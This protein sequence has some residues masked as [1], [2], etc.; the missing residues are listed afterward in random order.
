M[1]GEKGISL[2]SLPSL[3][4][5][6][7]LPLRILLP[8]RGCSVHADGP[9]DAV[10]IRKG[11]TLAWPAPSLSGPSCVPVTLWTLSSQPANGMDEYVCHYKICWLLTHCTFILLQFFDSQYIQ[12]YKLSYSLPPWYLATLPVHILYRVLIVLHIPLFWKVVLTAWDVWFESTRQLWDKC[13]W[14]SPLVTAG[15]LSDSLHQFPRYPFYVI[16]SHL[17]YAS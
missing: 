3:S 16:T 6:F 14:P 10:F 13:E 12:S 11:S 5:L 8:L 1:T 15:T 2:H 7:V 17:F 4:S 9:V